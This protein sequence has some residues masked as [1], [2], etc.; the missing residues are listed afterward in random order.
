M[1]LKKKIICGVIATILI[2]GI[3]LHGIQNSR[4]ENVNKTISP[5]ENLN[6]KNI[7]LTVSAKPDFGAKVNTLED[8]TE[9]AKGGITYGKVIDI[10]VYCDDTGTVYSTYL[11]KVTKTVEGKMT[12][13]DVIKV[14]DFGGIISADEYFEKQTDPKA[15]ELAQQCKGENNFVNYIFGN[16]ETP[17]IGKEYVWYLGK[18]KNDN[19]IM[20]YTPICSYEGILTVDKSSNTAEHHT[21]DEKNQKIALS[22]I[23]K[24][25]KED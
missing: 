4:D 6:K 12:K 3:G 13:G 21:E 10:S 24:V 7:V 15:L 5:R 19:G 14:T 8:L 2:S 16:A 22:E 18:G 11:I 20:H 23:E 1:I 9:L 17:K 25:A